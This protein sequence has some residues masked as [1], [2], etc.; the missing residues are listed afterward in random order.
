MSGL[1]GNAAEQSAEDVGVS[2]TAKIVAETGRFL[3]ERSRAYGP[4]LEKQSQT[5]DQ[6]AVLMQDLRRVPAIQNDQKLY[7]AWLFV[8]QSPDMPTLDARLDTLIRLLDVGGHLKRTAGDV[9][10]V[11]AGVRRN[12]QIIDVGI[13][14]Q[15]GGG[16][17]RRRMRL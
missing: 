4:S 17:A 15:V 16:S 5:L 8:T 9:I 11:D 3:D 6:L 1:G 13:V 7:D 10:G 12:S 14:E 2:A